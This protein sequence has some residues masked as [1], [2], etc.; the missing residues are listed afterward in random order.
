[1]LNVDIAVVTF[2]RLLLFP[3]GSAWETKICPCVPLVRHLLPSITLQLYSKYV[4]IDP[5]ETGC[6][7]RTIHLEKKCFTQREGPTQLLLQQKSRMP[8]ARL[9]KMGIFSIDFI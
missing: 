1:M 8:L 3:K 4:A 6:P 9:A 5:W 2:R 7:L